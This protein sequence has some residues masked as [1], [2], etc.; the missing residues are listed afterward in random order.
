MSDFQDLFSRQAACYARSRPCYPDAL[1]DYLAGITT[2]RTLAWDVGTGNGQAA[3][4]LAR[5]FESVVATDGSAEQIA[6]AV[7]NSRITYHVVLAESAGP[8]EGLTD[9]SVD[10]VTIAQALH[11]FATEAFFAN[12]RRALHDDGIIAA[13]CYGIHRIEPAIDAVA[14]RL[15]HEIIGPFWPP[16]RQWVDDGY[17]SI[18]FPFDESRFRCRVDRTASGGDV[19]AST[20]TCR[21]SWNLLQYVGYLSSWSAVQRFIDARGYNPL[22]E[23][24]A[25]LR[26]AWGEPASRRIVEWPIHLRVGML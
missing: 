22:D 2:R 1:F 21:E 9:R 24:E 12:A 15:Y 10:L 5:H 6:N 25:A 20:F 3:V 19:A 13:W 23:I 17:Q 16:D 8:R 26:S 7:P 14:G 11:W 18:P 4:G